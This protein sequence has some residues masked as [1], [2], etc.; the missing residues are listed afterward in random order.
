M[1]VKTHVMIINATVCIYINYISGLSYVYLYNEPPA[2]G[3]PSILTLHLYV[4]WHQTATQC[5]W[6]RGDL[7]KRPQVQLSL[8]M[9]QKPSQKFAFRLHTFYVH[10]VNA[11]PN[12]IVGRYSWISTQPCMT[13]I[14]NNIPTYFT[15]WL[16]VTLI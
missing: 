9:C 3:Q 14:H 8:S 13:I 4:I 1:D 12:L 2:S 6:V 5:V 11:E 15:G 16:H 7:G 10:Q